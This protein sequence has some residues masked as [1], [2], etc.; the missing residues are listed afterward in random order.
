MVIT[1]R[2]NT[3]YIHLHEGGREQDNERYI[4]QTGCGY[5]TKYCVY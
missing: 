1:D 4:H 5:I 2:Y 3:V